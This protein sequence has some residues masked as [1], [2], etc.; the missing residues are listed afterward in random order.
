[1][2]VIYRNHNSGSC[3]L[4]LSGNVLAYHWILIFLTFHINMDE[5]AFKYSI[6]II[7]LFVL[8]LLFFSQS[9]YLFL[10]IE[11]IFILFLFCAHYI[12]HLLCL[13]QDFQYA[14]VLIIFLLLWQNTWN[15]QLK[16][17][18]RF[19]AFHAFRGFSLWLLGPVV[20]D[21]WWH[22][23][24][25]EH[26]IRRTVHLIVARRAKTESRRGQVLNVALQGH[27]PMTSLLSIRPPY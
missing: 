10:L 22:S 26:V 3:F 6:M 17:E 25:L 18:K 20:L 23:T 16:K 8:S 12:I 2:S 1:V 7:I 11:Y 9:F 24:Y 27:V 14:S 4:L 21:L 13:L 5:D 15:N 19:I